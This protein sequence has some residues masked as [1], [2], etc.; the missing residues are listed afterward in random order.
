VLSFI[1]FFPLVGIAIIA[2]LPRERERYSRWVAAATAFVVL[3]AALALFAAF[4]RDQTGFQFVQH[5]TWIS[6]DIGHFDIQYLLGVDGLSLAMVVLTA[7]LAQVAVLISWR[8]E[9]RPKEYFAWLLL[10]ETSLLGVFTALDFLL[11]FV[12]WEIE[13]I[14][15]YF[16]ISIWGTGRKVYSA[17]KYVF[18][19]F[20]GSAFMLVGLLV[21]AFAANTFDIRVLG[22][23]EIRDALLP[24]QVIFFLLL[25]GFAIKLPVFPF[26]TW[27]PDAHTDAPTAVSVMLAGVLLKMGG[28]GILRI[29]LT[30]LPDVAREASIWL[31]AF[32]VVNILYGA[33]VTLVQTDLK[34]LIA[35][36]SISHMG[37]VLVGI[38]ALELVGLTGAGMQMFTHGLITGL[39]FVMVG[40]VY[41]RAH[42][43]QIGELSGLAHQMPMIAVVMIIA[44]LAS[45]GLPSMAG[46]VSE[47]L[48][49]LG[50]FGKYGGLTVLAVIGIL[51]TAAYI[52]WMV[53]RV[54]LGERM[55]RWEGLG[56]AT[57]WWE[58]AAMVAMVGVIFLIGVYPAVLADVIETGVQPIVG[59]LV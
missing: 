6:S 2:L 31:A 30:I 3:V 20:F 48:I 18:F 8:I 43:R 28:Y 4:D 49:F 1:V 54:F 45:L 41:D 10:M 59:R 52:L 14:P 22:Q 40:L 36:S 29:C 35:Y 27:L 58:R 25:F 9:L 32:G 44:G 42:T 5:H 19:T 17:W 56:D 33:L 34:R 12:F 50:T 57:A 55:A 21:L 16:L 53:Q 13:L 47:V 24:T 39:L 46:F 7:L 38:S 37:Y 15:M 51:L 11:F 23:A 26:H